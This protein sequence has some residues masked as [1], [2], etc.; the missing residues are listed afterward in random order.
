MTTLVRLRDRHGIAG[1]FGAAV[2]QYGAFDLSKTPSQRNWGDRNLVLSEPIVDWFV[3]NFLPGRDPEARRDPDISP[4]YA[5]LR[6]M[7]PALFAVGTEDMLLD[8]TLF[9]EARWRL[10]GTATELH[11]WP[12]AP[13]GFVSLPMAAADRELATEHAFLRATLRL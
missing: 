13:H 2:L 11:V 1:A 8:D 7:P 3:E 4:L 6:G 5:D 12:S 9:M 10:G